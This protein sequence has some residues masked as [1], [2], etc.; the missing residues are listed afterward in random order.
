MDQREPD[1]PE[2]QDQEAATEP[3][4]TS[5][6]V[7]LR[8]I[9]NVVYA[10]GGKDFG[11]IDRGPDRYYFDPRLVA[12]EKR[13]VRGDTVFFTAR[14]P[15]QEGGRPIAACVLV[16]GK[17]AVGSVVNILPSGRAC[18]LAVTD[19]LGHHYNVYMGLPE[20]MESVSLGDRI[21]FIADENR[22]GPSAL[23]P[24]RVE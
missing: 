21:R 8:G 16:K 9:V 13:P 12:A 2:S 14:P 24:G 15:L 4:A 19:G 17:P 23:R 18:F 5:F 22:K 6:E 7:V 1:A 3:D 11:Y 20:T 10:D